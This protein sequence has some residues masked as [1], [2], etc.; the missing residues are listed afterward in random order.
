LAGAALLLALVLAPA[1]GRAEDDAKQ[2]LKAMSDYLAGQMNFSVTY[3]SDVEVITPDLQKIQFT[4]SGQMRVSRPDMMQASRT[5]GYADVA[6]YLD[7]KTLTII[8]KDANSYAQ[9]DAPGSIDQTIDFVR[10]NGAEV[11]GADLLLADVYDTLMEGVLDAKH[12][13]EGVVGGI[14]CEHL[15]FRNEDTDWQIWIERGD[16]PIPR[17][18]V[19]TSKAVASGPQYTLRITDWKEGGASADAFSYTPPADAKKVDFKDLSQMDEVPEGAVIGGS[20]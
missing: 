2:I 11:P 3:D 8:N 1:Q 18:Y 10:N 7:G 20:K 5:G 14:E 17:K 4:S 12:I 6:L 9:G 15:A 16:R 13:G 19:I